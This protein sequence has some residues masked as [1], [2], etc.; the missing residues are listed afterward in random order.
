[1]MFMCHQ[2]VGYVLLTMDSF[3]FEQKRKEK[4]WVWVHWMNIDPQHFWLK[5][6]RKTV[7]VCN[8]FTVKPVSQRFILTC[9]FMANKR[10]DTG[11]LNLLKINS[12]GRILWSHFVS[13]FFPVL[14]HRVIQLQALC[15]TVLCILT[16]ENITE[17]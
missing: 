13:F 2:K 6:F 12:E 8:Y 4:K 7:S 15:I 11:Y 3:I 14:L 5:T 10:L 1:M 16:L 17:I 9:C